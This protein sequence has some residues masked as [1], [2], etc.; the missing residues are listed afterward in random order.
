MHLEPVLA[1]VI[2]VVGL[3][4][5]AAAA[6]IWLKRVQFPFVA[7]TD[8]AVQR[9]EGGRRPSGGVSRAIVQLEGLGQSGGMTATPLASPAPA[10]PVVF[11][12]L[13]GDIVPLR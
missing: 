13:P 5:I 12:D 9:R 2:A 4:L 3:L 7:L 11:L 10:N 8:A 6:S 1:T